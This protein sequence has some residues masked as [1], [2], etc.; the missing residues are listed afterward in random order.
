M[1]KVKPKEEPKI[2]TSKLTKEEIL[3]LDNI[4]LKVELLKRNEKEIVDKICVR[5]GKKIDNLVSLN[6]QAGEVQFAE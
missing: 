5:L 2:T 6:T 4:S 1:S 3:E